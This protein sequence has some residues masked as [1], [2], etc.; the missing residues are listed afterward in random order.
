M[1]NIINRF[2]HLF[3]ARYTNLS[4]YAKRKRIL[5]KNSLMV[6]LK[7]DNTSEFST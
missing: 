6:G 5:I 1:P 4:V 7:A 3:L 2:I